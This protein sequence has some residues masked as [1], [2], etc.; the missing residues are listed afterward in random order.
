MDV[1]FHRIKPAALP[2][3]KQEYLI[4]KDGQHIA[5]LF[6]ACLEWIR[7][8]P[9]SQERPVAKRCKVAFGRSLAE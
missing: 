2:V 5:Q 3:E 7:I 1:L 6:A 9:E 4:F 8:A